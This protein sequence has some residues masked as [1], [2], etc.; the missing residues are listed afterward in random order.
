M[1]ELHDRRNDA[2]LALRITIAQLVPDPAKR[3]RLKH[4]I[5]HYVSLTA[6]VAAEGMAIQAIKE[7][8]KPQPDQPPIP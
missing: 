8:F 3:D 7:A 2:L 1:S 5:D 4:D 6:A